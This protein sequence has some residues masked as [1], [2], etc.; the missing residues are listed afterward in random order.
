MLFDCVFLYISRLI[1]VFQPSL[2][3]WPVSMTTNVK[4]HSKF[5]GDAMYIGS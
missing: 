2:Q 1:R 5:G 3:E 4:S